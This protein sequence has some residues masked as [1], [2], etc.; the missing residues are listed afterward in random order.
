MIFS[1]YLRS[2]RFTESAAASIEAY[3]SCDASLVR[4]TVPLTDITISISWFFSTDGFLSTFS[5]TSQPVTWYTANNSTFVHRRRRRHQGAD[6]VSE[7]TFLPTLS[8]AEPTLSFTYF[9]SASVSCSSQH[10][11]QCHT[12]KTNARQLNTLATKRLSFSG[13]SHSLVSL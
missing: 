3:I 2:L 10:K 6:G 12:L 7:R 8:I 1:L 4:S 5:V 13:P 9:L 11:S